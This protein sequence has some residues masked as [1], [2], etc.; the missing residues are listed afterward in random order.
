MVPVPVDPVERG[1]DGIAGQLK[2]F[3][4]KEKLGTIDRPEQTS[5]RIDLTGTCDQGS[6]DDALGPGESTTTS[7][8]WKADLVKDVPVR[9][10][11]IRFN[12]SVRFDPGDPL[13][14]DGTIHVVGDPPKLLTA[15][16][17]VDSMLSDRRFATWLGK[18]PAKTW[19]AAHAMLVHY[20][21]AEGI[22]P[23]GPSWDI[24]I[25]REVGIPRN[26]AIGFID[27]FTGEIASLTFC[28]DPCDR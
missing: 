5:T 13:S 2:A 24:E 7:F 14:V 21:A 11:D 4:L 27:P 19:G 22:V 15:G 8:K 28:N 10:G 20:P 1:W 26:W 12:V 6:P 23:A 17:A 16:Q 25:F 3:M 9:P 18:Q